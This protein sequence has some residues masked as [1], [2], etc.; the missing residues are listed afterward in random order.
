MKEDM[1]LYAFLARRPSHYDALADLK[2]AI[3]RFVAEHC[4]AR[5]DFDV[6]DAL[7]RLLADGLVRADAARNLTAI[8]PE[9]ARAHLDLLWDR[10]LDVDTLD[11]A[12]LRPAR[13]ERGNRPGA[14]RHPSELSGE[15]PGRCRSGRGDRLP[16]RGSGRAAKRSPFP[17]STAAT[18]ASR[19][20][21]STPSAPPRDALI[22]L[23]V[24]DGA[25]YGEF[26]IE[27]LAPTDWVT[28][29][30]GKRSPVHAGRFLVHGSHDRGRVAPR[31]LAIEIDAG[32]AFG[33]AHHAST[34]GCSAGARRC[35]EARAPERDPRCWDRHR[36]SRHRRGKSA[37]TRGARQR[38]RP[39]RGRDRCR[40][41]R[42][43]P[44][45]AARQHRHR[46]RFRASSPQAG[47]GRPASR[48]SSRAGPLRTCA[49]SCARRVKS[50]GMAILSGLTETQA[51][52]IEARTSA[53]GFILEK[54]IILD[55]WTTLMLRRRNGRAVGD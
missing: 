55:G 36:H 31:R 38:R 3:E 14:S 53:F 35:L 40:Q 16:P 22:A 9:E 13:H 37:A 15:P 29:S 52:G 43:E 7:R 46:A 27:P 50:G 21:R 23:A 32:Q 12:P 17:C 28:L 4:G 19:S 33:T 51:R 1:L 11:Q 25:A 24:R 26:R 41:H 47:Q 34:R 49:R 48:Q 54:R 20:R 2:C 10:L 45:K 30:Q 8:A 39:A 42:E 18:D 5:I 6:E 44:R